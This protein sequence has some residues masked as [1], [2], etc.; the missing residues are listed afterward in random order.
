MS[1]HGICE[2][3]HGL[4]E[5]VAIT[6][7]TNVD[8][9]NERLGVRVAVIVLKLMKTKCA[10]SEISNFDC[11]IPGLFAMLHCMVFVLHSLFLWDA[12][13]FVVLVLVEEL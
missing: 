10:M 4:K 9:A 8:L 7:S 1:V 6:L 3:I 13:V 5:S 12:D 11:A 2:K